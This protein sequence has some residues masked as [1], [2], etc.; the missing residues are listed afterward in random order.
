[1]ITTFTKAEQNALISL[2][3]PNYKIAVIPPGVEF[4]KFSNI[5]VDPGETLRLGYLG[6][7]SP[8]KGVHRL[9]PLAK[10]LQ[11]DRKWEL[12]LSGL[13]QDPHYSESVLSA[14]ASYNNV[15]YIGTVDRNNN[16]SFFANIHVL[17][18]PS[19]RET[20]GITVLEAM[21]AGRVV[22]ASNIYP[23]DEF[24][25]NGKTGFLVNPENFADQAFHILQSLV[26]D[27]D[28]IVKIGTSARL[29]VSPYNW[30]NIIS[31]YENLYNEACR[32]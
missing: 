30:S 20:G 26:S 24:I 9:V 3:V 19:V 6:R 25:T 16:T 23:V 28:M 11:K 27:P 31:L 22:I 10:L 5:A 1:V 21:S 2:K 15:R 13:L 7:F 4:E 12:Y 17:L 8:E 32:S 29:S 18:F 14:L